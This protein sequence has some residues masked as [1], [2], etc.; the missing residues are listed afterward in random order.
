MKKTKRVFF[1]IIDGFGVG[2]L[3]DF[4]QYD[5]VK[6]NTYQNLSD[7]LML[8]IPNLVKLGIN[9]ID[10]LSIEKSQNVLGSFG[11]LAVKNKANNSQEGFW[12]MGGYFLNKPFEIFSGNIPDYLVM[13]I[14][15]AIKTKTLCNHVSTFSEA[16]QRYGQVA[17]D[18]KQPIIYS[19]D[20]AS[21]I[22]I[23]FHEDVCSLEELLRT[24]KKVR[25]VVGDEV[26]SVMA[27]QYSGTIGKFYRSRERIEFNIMPKTKTAFD[28]IK[29]NGQKV[30]VLG[31]VSEM[32]SDNS[33]SEL[34]LAKTNSLQIKIIEKLIY[35][36]FEEGLLISYLSDTDSVYAHKND[37][38]GY[39]KCLE[40]IDV[41]LGAV[42]DGMTDDDVLIV[43]S[44]HGNDPTNL[45]SNHSREY[46]PFLIYG[47]GVKK[48]VNIDTLDSLEVIGQ[49]I[50][51]I[52]C[53]E[54]G[55]R[56]IWEEVSL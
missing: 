54:K 51:E 18:L 43:S 10:G 30:V 33:V 50:K 47:K 8:N 44:D 4:K 27:V 32:M 55:S 23:A 39:R 12:E 41:M 24:A 49:T 15:N 16:V 5:V 22:E 20:Y 19:C 11:R 40:E 7:K 42:M 37:F 45:S 17:C 56:S 13:A 36:G 3:P 52:L 35:K 6:S 48:G 29:N 31:K 38:L 46:V 25:E 14:E 1:I 21:R 28:E 53:G 2:N 9:E 26:G 34:Y